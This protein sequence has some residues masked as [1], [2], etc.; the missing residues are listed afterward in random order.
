MKFLLHVIA[1][2]K[3]M[4]ATSWWLRKPKTFVYLGSN[5]VLNVTFAPFAAAAATLGVATPPPVLLAQGIVAAGAFIDILCGLA[6]LSGVGA[7]RLCV[8]FPER[9][10]SPRT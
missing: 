3:K 1:G 6:L 8:P 2:L 9:A 10:N 4:F 7:G 5:P